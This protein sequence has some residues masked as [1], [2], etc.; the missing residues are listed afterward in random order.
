MAVIDYILGAICLVILLL[1]VLCGSAVMYVV[2]MTVYTFAYNVSKRIEN[3]IN[4]RFNE[5]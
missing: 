4:E 5:I 2:A 1:I 3:K